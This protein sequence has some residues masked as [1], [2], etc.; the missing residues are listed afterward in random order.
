MKKLLFLL[1]FLPLISFSQTYT[2]KK[3]YDGTYEVK[4]SKAGQNA[5]IQGA[6]DMYR[7]K[8]LQYRNQ[9]SNSG[10]GQYFNNY[11]YYHIPTKKKGK[12]LRMN[13]EICY[14]LITYTFPSTGSYMFDDAVKE[15]EY[16]DAISKI[17]EYNELV[18]LGFMSTN[19]Y[20]NVVKLFNNKRYQDVY[21]FRR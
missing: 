13:C 14:K 6:A 10:Y 20:N 17:K 11:Y 1:M 3:K 7:S 8:T 4:D 19:D 21:R 2:V 12:S 9:Q 5:L 16:K 15:H 18:G